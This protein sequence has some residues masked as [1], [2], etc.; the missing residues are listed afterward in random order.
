MDFFNTADL[1][2]DILINPDF[3]KPRG[4]EIDYEDPKEVAEFIAW[5]LA[6]IFRATFREKLIKEVEKLKQNREVELGG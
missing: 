6:R 4:A 2:N 3:N 1:I 5:H